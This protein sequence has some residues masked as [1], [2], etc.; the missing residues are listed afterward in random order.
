[1]SRIYNIVRRCVI[2]ASNINP[3]IKRERYFHELSRDNDVN[4]IVFHMLACACSNSLLRILY[5]SEF[6]EEDNRLHAIAGEIVETRRLWE[7]DK[8]DIGDC[9]EVLLCRVR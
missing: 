2:L 4:Y 3:A 8:E 6:F 1:M 9:A 5:V 7:E